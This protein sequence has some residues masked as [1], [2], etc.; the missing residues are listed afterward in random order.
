MLKKSK[1]NMD[2]DESCTAYPQDDPQF[3]G[4]TFYPIS[5]FFLDDK[6]DDAIPEIGVLVLQ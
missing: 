5:G 1:R 3:L 4:I 2:L 6:L